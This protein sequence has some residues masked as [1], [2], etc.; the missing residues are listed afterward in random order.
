MDP[1]DDGNI[2]KDSTN[3]RWFGSL[4]SE[5]KLKEAAEGVI[6]KNTVNNTRWAENNFLVWAKERNKRVV[7]DPVPMDL[8]E[9]QDA[10]LVNKHLCCYVLETRRENGSHYPPGTMRSLLSDLMQHSKA[11]FSVFDKNNLRFR[12]LMHTLDAI[13]SDLHRQGIGAQRKHASVI[14]VDDENV[15]WEQGKFCDASPRVL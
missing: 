5:K 6:P 15:L 13:S 1:E 11:P 7:D 4:S 8:L 14:T 2:F 10:N 12:D 9:S 3:T